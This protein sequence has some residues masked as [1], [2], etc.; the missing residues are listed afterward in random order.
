[1]LVYGYGGFWIYEASFKS[2]YSRNF[3]RGILGEFKHVVLAIVIYLNFEY[4][5]SVCGCVSGLLTVMV[6][7]Y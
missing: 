2:S 4:S 5:Q 7:D 1:M 6:R 3:L